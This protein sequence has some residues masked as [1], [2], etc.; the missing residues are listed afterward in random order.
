[1]TRKLLHSNRKEEQV[2][3]GIDRLM[4]PKKNTFQ[5]EKEKEKEK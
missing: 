1:M 3:P 5:K 4:Y 2:A